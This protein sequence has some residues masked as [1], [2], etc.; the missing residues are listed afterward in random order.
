M[1]IFNPVAT[2]FRVAAFALLF[3]CPITPADAQSFSAGLR[4]G[5]T[6]TQVDGDT[7]EGFD[8]AGLLG[9]IFV[10]RSLSERFSLRMELDYIQKGSRKPLD[11]DDNSYYRMRVNYLEVPF[12]ARYRAG[13]KITL[14]GGP[15]FGVL[16]FSQEDDQTGVLIY[17]PPF[18][19]YEY[20]ISAG[21]LY[22]LSEKVGVDVRYGFS[23]VPIRPFDFYA[24]FVYWDKGQFNSVIQLSLQ[25]RFGSGE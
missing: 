19:K 15:A 2:S 4:A 6:A 23:V 8:K 13:K 3:G 17:S 5:M 7:Y 14:Q 11:K 12:V 16:V 18:R 20:S 24:T 21:L 1:R 10:E 22:D 9:G 25:Y